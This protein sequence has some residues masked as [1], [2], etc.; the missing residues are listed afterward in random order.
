MK[1]KRRHTHTQR[2]R[3]STQPSQEIRWSACKPR[4]GRER[5]RWRKQEAPTE[6]GYGWVCVML[7]KM[8]F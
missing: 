7:A 3:E 5:R 4:K 2:K 8:D 1:K 6:D